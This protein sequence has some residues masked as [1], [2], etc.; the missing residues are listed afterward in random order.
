MSR[1][2]IAVFSA[3]MAGAAT[4]LAMGASVPAQASTKPHGMFTTIG[5]VSPY[6]TSKTITHWS[7]S[8]SYKGTTYPYTMVGTNPFTTKS[9]TTTPTEIIPLNLV[10]SNGAQ[11]NGSDIV[12]D[13]VKSP[14]FQVSSFSQSGDNTQYGDAIF[15]SQFNLVGSKYHVLLGQPTVL[16][17]QTISVPANQGTTVSFGG[18]TIGDVAIQWW[19]TRLQH[20]LG[21]LHIS[22]T[23]LPI[24]LTKDTY[25][26]EARNPQDCCVG[27]FHGAGSVPSRTGGNLGNNGKAP[28]QTYAWATYGTAEAIPGNTFSLD[29]NAIS[30]EVSEWQDD[31]FVQNVVPAWSVPDEPQ[32]GCSNVLET[33][34]PLVGVSF[35]EDGY[36][37]QDEA[38]F[39]WFAHQVPSIA[40][41]GRYSYLG[42]FTS[43]APGC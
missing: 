11:Y 19:A 43:P 39:S 17:A 40:Q 15:R 27:G 31:P 38:F 9:T 6:P 35:N 3:V 4:T 1:R 13:V 2:V 28:I 21:Q 5:G 32:Y 18:P 10:F 37:P 12:S 29:I 8:F 42:T 23:T 24:F 30:H 41:G 25:L 34:D 26:Y 14:M 16:P 7:S 36:H 20:L 22:T 33:G